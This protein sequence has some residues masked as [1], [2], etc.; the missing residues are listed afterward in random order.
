[1]IHRIL[2]GCAFALAAALGGCGDS[3]P[4]KIPDWKEGFTA[5]AELSDDQRAALKG[6]RKAA[7]EFL[8]ILSQRTGY[9]PGSTAS[10]PES[11]AKYKRKRSAVFD[12]LTKQEQGRATRAGSS[13][14]QSGEAAFETSFEWIYDLEDMPNWS[15]D[16]GGLRANGEA[17]FE[18]HARGSRETAILHIVVKK[19][20]KGNWKV[21]RFDTY[22]KYPS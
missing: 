18:L 9:R 13:R 6:A 10:G 17:G 20:E 8:A 7:E 14:G 15:I 1:M 21:D 12:C 2:A 16:F 11:E 5:E 22:S 4:P 3:T 19:D